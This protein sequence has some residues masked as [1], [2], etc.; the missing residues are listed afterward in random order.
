MI[1]SSNRTRSKGSCQKYAGG[2]LTILRLYF[3]IWR[4]KFYQDFLPSFNL[5][6]IIPKKFFFLGGGQTFKK[7]STRLTQNL[8]DLPKFYRT[9]PQL[10]WLTQNL[11]NLSKIYRTYPWS[12]LSYRPAILHGG[13]YGPP[14]KMLK[15]FFVK[16]CYNSYIFNLL[17]CNLCIS[18]LL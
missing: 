4:R 15:Q 13:L 17:Y 9:Y 6:V 10:T 3:G 7:G 5:A 16:K 2:M 11:P 14:E 12:C 18:L 1:V 8:P